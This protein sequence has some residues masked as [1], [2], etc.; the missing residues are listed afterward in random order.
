MHD[1]MSDDQEADSTIVNLSVQ[2]FTV[3]SVAHYLVEHKNGLSKLLEFFTMI[4]EDEA[5]ENEDGQLD[6]TDWYLERQSDYFRS[7][8]ILTDIQYLLS[9]PPTEKPWSTEMRTNFI[10]A[11]KKLIDLVSKLQLAD[12]QARQTGSHV[13]Y[14]SRNWHC[15]FTIASTL[16]QLANMAKAWCK[17]DPAVLR[18]IA[19]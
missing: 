11:A 4:F 8:H 7:T 2:I 16:M 9:S 10:E 13:E 1:Y 17:E 19:K 14:E 3:P 6:L 5:K 15:V 18:P 12:P